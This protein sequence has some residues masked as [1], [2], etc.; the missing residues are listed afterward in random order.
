M[1][2]NSPNFPCRVKI[3]TR[4]KSNANPNTRKMKTTTPAPSPQVTAPATP[5][6]PVK[7]KTPTPAELKRLTR[8][9]EPFFFT[10]STMDFFGDTMG[11]YGCRNAGPIQTRNGMVACWELYRRRP[12]RH[13]LR[14][15]A[16]FC[17]ATLRRVFPEAK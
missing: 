8:E 1:L 10:R 7:V 16:Y 6:R 17:K 9:T 13:G 11:N 14:D 4:Q 15:S 2:R 5:S 12:V 3:L